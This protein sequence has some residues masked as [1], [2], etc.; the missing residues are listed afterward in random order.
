MVT[1]L[2]RVA[3][4]P[5]KIGLQK[6][7]GKTSVR[8]AFG[9]IFN[10]FLL[11]IQKAFYI[12]K[13]QAKGKEIHEHKITVTHLKKEVK[14]EKLRSGRANV[15]TFQEILKKL[16]RKTLNVTHK[17]ITYDETKQQKF[18]I[19]TIIGAF[20]LRPKQAIDNWK[21][22]VNSCRNG[23]ILD[24]VKAEKLKGKMIRIVSRTTRDCFQRI[25]G[26]GD[27]V[28]GAIKSVIRQV[29]KRRK[30]ALNLWVA[31]NHECRHGTLLNAIKSEKLRSALLKVPSRVMRDAYQRV[32][33]DG[34]KIKGAVRTVIKQIEKRSK[35]SYM[36]WREYVVKCKHGDLFDGIRSQKLKI[37]LGN[38]TRR[39]LRDCA[40]RMFGAGDKV[41]AVIKDIIRNIE[42][43]PQFAFIKWKAFNEECKQGDLLDAIK[44][45]KLR[46]ALMRVP[47]RTLRNGFQIILGDGNKVKGAIKTIVRQVEKKPKLVLRKWKKVVIDIKHGD[48]MDACR[49][50]KLRGALNRVPR[51]ILRDSIQRI[52]GNGA[53]I[54]GA[55]KTLKHSIERRPA[56]AIKKWKV[57]VLECHKGKMFDC[58]RA[59]Q[60]NACLTR[61]P[62]RTLRSTINRFQGN[63]NVLAGVFKGFEYRFKSL[64][65]IALS[66][67]KH[68]FES[69]KRGEMLD[70]M[71]AEKLKHS[72]RRIPIRTMRDG[73][74]R[75]LGDGNKTA[76]ALKNL[77]RVYQNLLS[78]S[79]SKWKS[80]VKDCRSK[81]FLDAL[82]SERLKSSLFRITLRTLKTSQDKIIGMGNAVAGALRQIFMGCEK[83]Q[84]VGF[85][86]WKKFIVDCK[87]KTITNNAISAK[88]KNAL[89]DIVKRTLKITLSQLTYDKSIAKK[90]LS[91]VFFIIRQR[92]KNAVNKWKIHVI[93]CK[94][95]TV[96]DNLKSH[97][98]KIAL[99]RLPMRTLRGG[100][101]RILG[102][103]NRVKGAI[104]Q[105]VS[106]LM[107]R[108]KFSIAKWKEFVVDCHKKN[109]Y[110]NV[111]SYK[112]KNI[113]TRLQSRPLRNYIE[114]ILGEGNLVLGAI[115]KICLAIKNKPRVALRQ[116]AKYIE[117]IRRNEIF[118]NF[119]SQKLKI[120]LQ[121]IPRRVIKDAY[122]RII[123]DGN[124]VKGTIKGIVSRIIKMPKVAITKWKTFVHA[125]K[126]KGLLDEIRSHKLHSCLTRIPKR[127]LR[128]AI[129]RVKDDGGLLSNAFRSLE[130]RIKKI[131]R[132]AMNKW[133]DVIVDIKNGQ[134]LT[135]MKASQLKETLRK[136]PIRT[137]R[138]GYQ[139][140]LG[141]GNKTS[142]ALKNL[143]RVYQNLLKNGYSQWKSYVKDCQSQKFLDALK[144]EKLKASLFRITL[145]T[146]KTSQDKIIGMGNAVIG[147]I[148]RMFMGCEKIQKVG[149]NKWTKYVENCKHKNIMNNAISAKLKIALRDIIKRS[150]KNTI[151]LLVSS[152]GRVRKAIS[153]IFRV[154]KQ[155]PRV[156]INLWKTHVVNCKT[157]II[158]D[159]LKS[160]KLKIALG[161]VP[162]RTLR[163]GY[164]RILG[165]G[166]RVKG[167]I[168]Q[169]VS[170]LM[171]RPKF[172]IAKW[173]EF[174]VDCHKKNLYDNVRSYKIKNILTRLQSRSLR[175]YVERILG[176]GNLVLGAI[177]KLCLAHKNK[178]RLA[179]R[180]WV[181][182]AEHVR[183]NEIFD[184][185]RSEKLKNSLTKIPVRTLRNLFERVIGDGDIVKGAI[186]RVLIAFKNITRNAF[187]NWNQFNIACSKKQLFDNF[188]SQKLK[189]SLQNIPRRVIKDA[190]ERIIGDGN[191]VKGALKSIVSRI[192]KMPYT[193]IKKWRTFV[194]SCKSKGLLDEIRSHKLNICLT[195]IPKRVIRDVS[196][197]ILGERKKVSGAITQVIYQFEKK[198]QFAI[199]KWHKTIIDIKEGALLDACR[200]EKLKGTL[201]KVPRRVLR[202]AMQRII[203]NS[204]KA[205]GALRT[206]KHSI[207]KRIS[208]SMKTWKTF[209]ID[210]HKGAILDSLRAHKL[211]SCLNRIPKRTLRSVLNRFEGNGNFLIGVFKGLER[212]LNDL[213]KTAVAKWKI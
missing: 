18:S 38:L 157:Q 115:K 187:D 211:N 118:D 168:K 30:V 207:E 193:A 186:R 185:L 188:R 130:N 94:N 23:D 149:F 160:Y 27:K 50:E 25:V 112:I 98:L 170:N 59:Y 19:K 70:A 197:R 108:P 69:C 101:E 93:N 173:K 158:L 51:R 92:P 99:G 192:L 57:F 200:T 83:L 29:E 174:V 195:R 9:D 15:K 128:N 146:L 121:N 176:E 35:V 66:K 63:G 114:R 111:R 34:N 163:G 201:N 81:K 131:P 42:K 198:V 88:L 82:K 46:S 206:L 37:A 178:P 58:L 190:Y 21:A 120:S 45:E 134:L 32:I 113:L 49:S 96:L 72:L 61:I 31:Y 109:L 203:G 104:K 77:F 80:Y 181:K 47:R 76:G 65:R 189:I 127:T 97:K 137:L 177:K 132:L 183:H 116:W 150:L 136:I 4:K 155:R 2:K 56:D 26:S 87:N 148:K 90:A 204:S 196:K 172:S 171:N 153:H 53:K 16:M 103:G 199:R 79:C 138:D 159:N 39:T 33:G 22:F 202:D 110:D 125:C 144:S 135:A 6:F 13:L 17:R 105:L 124:K 210:C 205:A 141:N 5:Q 73:Y 126:T 194:N 8:N 107:N 14:K 122:E 12:C 43:R 7:I 55:L 129:N 89:K 175:S 71:K 182:Y 40:Q 209:V 165:D 212:R 91:Y 41:K 152:D 133:K 167:A 84:K 147:A 95:Q 52:I 28:K 142:G 179:L 154:I 119:R 44:T 161:R 169:L 48:L 145:R 67:W 184:N 62:R 3:R 139:R 143:F 86:S 20:I 213:P 140:I 54:S 156:A 123:G 11:R 1:A 162:M 36:K 117:L 106:N 151:V 208:M 24:R 180:H 64:P 75:I 100:Y 74:Q 78:N 10:L 191:K 60:L 102:D 166:D 85:N 68:W 164:E